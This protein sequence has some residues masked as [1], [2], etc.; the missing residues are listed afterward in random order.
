MEGR[1]LH[2]AVHPLQVVWD[3]HWK[4]KGLREAKEGLEQEG[5]MSDS[6]TN[7]EIGIGAG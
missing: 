3:A 5:R 1:Q 6:M 7:G 2:R 4:L